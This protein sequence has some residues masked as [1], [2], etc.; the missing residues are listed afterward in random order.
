MLP[1]SGSN[2]ISFCGRPIGAHPDS[3]VLLLLVE[4]AAGA[5]RSAK[6]APSILELAGALLMGAEA[7]P[8]VLL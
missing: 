7:A 1:G 4:L 5:D 2:S 8:S 6:P 3:L